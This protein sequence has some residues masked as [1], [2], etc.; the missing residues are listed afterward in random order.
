MSVELQVGTPLANALQSVVQPKLAEVGWSSGASDD[1][2]LSEYI[3]LMLVNGKTQEQ[4]ASELANDLLS[5]GP[6]DPDAANFSR[7]LFEQLHTLNSQLNGDAS[8]SSETQGGQRAFDGDQANLTNRPSQDAEMGDGTQTSIPTG[9]K[10]MRNG[11]QTGR[12]KRMMGHLSKAM[13]RSNDAALHRVR[14]G[15]GTGRINSHAGR[16]APKGPRHQANRNMAIMNG[17]GGMGGM[18]GMNGMGMPVP[19]NMMPP[20]SQMSQMDIFRTFEA[21]SAQMA[22]MSQAL[23]AKG[24]VPPQQPY[25]NPAFQKNFRGGPNQGKSLF[26]RVDPSSRP[27]RSKPQHIGK[28]LQGDTDMGEG[29]ADA[30]NNAEAMDVESK[31][32]EPWDIMCK[33]NSNCT[34]AKCPYAH[35][36]PMAAPGITVDLGD[37]CSFGVRCTNFKCTA[38]HPS[39]AQKMEFQQKNPCKFGM[40]CT[41]P[42]CPFQHPPKPC[43]FNESCTNPD[44]KFTHVDTK[45]K[46]TPC[47]NPHCFFKHDPGQRAANGSGKEHVSER[48][49]IDENQE[50]ELILPAK[51]QESE[52]APKAEQQEPEI[53][54]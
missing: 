27:N 17:M 23:A 48:K 26:D 38:K 7:W 18:P 6:D 20:Q 44:C 47:L 12:E 32:K 5:L 8:G 29:G 25:V 46:F 41:N 52:E 14:G 51:S 35:Q 11:N 33:F 16:E 19:G 42:G 36:A 39:P 9:P 1:T 24:Q 50:E 15:G 53:A 3:I 30:G 22:Q 13:E 31:D 37:Q 2:A 34:N 43:R 21:M 49:F 4:I 54:A 40:H 28:K 45:C 10:A